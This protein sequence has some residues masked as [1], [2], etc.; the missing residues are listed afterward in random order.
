MKT[1]L[2]LLGLVLFASVLSVSARKK[3]ARARGRV[4]CRINGRTYPILYAKVSL[5]D[6]DPI[7]YDTFGTTR[8]NGLGY[9]TV[10]GRAG[11]LFG[12]PDPYIQVEYKYSGFLGK[13]EVENG[14]GFN[15]HDK[16]R[17]KGY[18]SS[19]SFGNLYFGNDHCKAYVNTLSAMRNFRYRTRQTLPYKVLKVVTH[20]VLHGGTPYATTN[21]IRIPRRFNYNWRTARH[22]FAHT[23][24]HTLVS[25]IAERNDFKLVQHIILFI[26]LFM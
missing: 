8:T 13:M 14:L 24:R 5:L 11:D 2:L 18:S 12:N 16:T 23:I 7:G 26:L 15:R 1:L 9:F 6:K 4:L 22:E 25:Y 21:K 20:A 3:F 17:T 19:L 10:A